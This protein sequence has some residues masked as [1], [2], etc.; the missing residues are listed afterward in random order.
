[1]KKILISTIIAAGL[2]ISATQA[3]ETK[4]PV[5]APVEKTVAKKTV[6]PKMVAKKAVASK[7]MAVKGDF[8]TKKA[9]VA[10]NAPS[11]KGKIVAHI[12]K[13]EKLSIQSCDKYNWCQLAGK[14]EFI[15][16]DV[17]RKAK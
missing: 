10:R 14:K 15:S 4:A 1:M 3:A 6:A 8:L 12:K 13:G 17:L 11:R 16:R 7:K 9:A 5:K 2:L